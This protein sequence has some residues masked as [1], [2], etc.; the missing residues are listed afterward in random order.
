MKKTNIILSIL[1]AAFLYACGSSN[2]EE[3]SQNVDSTKTNV[4]IADENV[5]DN[6]YMTFKT[7]K[8]AG[9]KICIE[10]SCDKDENVWIDLN[11]NKKQDEGE[12]LSIA[13][14][15]YKGNEVYMEGFRID[16][17]ISVVNQDFTVYGAVK[18]LSCAGSGI[19]EVDL[20]NNPFLEHFYC[21]ENSLTS[22]NVDKNK[23][24]RTLFC[25][26]NDIS[27][28]NIANNAELEFLGLP[29]S[30]ETKVFDFE[31]WQKLEQL[32]KKQNLIP[33]NY[34]IIKL[35]ANNIESYDDIVANNKD[36]LVLF[37][38]DLPYADRNGFELPD[39]KLI[40]FKNKGDKTY[41]LMAEADNTPADLDKNSVQYNELFVENNKIH[42]RV[43]ENP[44][45]YKDVIYSMKNGKIVKE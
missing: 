2:G 35:M 45:E 30:I 44:D 9:D 16:P 42:Y 17:K 41:E 38:K 18:Y 34:H 11:N 15:L 28:I 6:P 5:P 8:Q 29:T 23:K 33:E 4:E 39:T 43:Y 7:D 40:Y 22:L 36:V 13:G 32:L 12:K 20:S 19:T 27:D 26:A 10:I 21:H 14:N 31:N 24:L 1:I 3:N 37:E 25:K